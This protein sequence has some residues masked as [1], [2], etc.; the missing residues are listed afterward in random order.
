MYVV[1]V[2]MVVP[3]S[4]GLHIV[5]KGGDGEKSAVI[6]SKVSF[7]GFAWRE[8]YQKGTLVRTADP[9]IVS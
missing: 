7:R 2:K 1:P 5:V 9:Q 4:H 3:C 8:G 6:C